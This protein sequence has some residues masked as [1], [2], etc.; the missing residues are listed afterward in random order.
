[1]QIKINSGV[2][3]V[4]GITTAPMPP[5]PPPIYPPPRTTR[6]PYFDLG[7]GQGKV[8][9][10]VDIPMLG[11]CRY[12]V[13][14]FHIGIGLDGYG[15]FEMQGFTLGSFL[16]DYLNVHDMGDAY[17]SGFNMAAHAQGALPT[18]WCDVA[19]SMFSISQ[20]RP[21]LEPIQIPTDTELFTFHIKILEKAALGLHNLSCLD[22]HYYTQKRH[23]RRDFLYTTNTDSEFARGGVTKI[24][25]QGGEL[26]VVA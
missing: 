20:S 21:P 5:V 8:G 18:E 2:L 4:D 3:N 26:T 25:T 10:V 22:E 6:E 15:N 1:M 13:N 24:D 7:D 14:G 9:E 17:W 11:G 12:P 19:V 23:R 16:Q